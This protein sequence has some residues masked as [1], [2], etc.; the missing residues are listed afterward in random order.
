M[1]RLPGPE[2]PVSPRFYFSTFSLFWIISSNTAAGSD[3]G[4]RLGGLTAGRT[5]GRRNT[6]R[7]AGTGNAESRK[8]CWEEWWKGSDQLG[9]MVVETEN[10][11]RNAGRSQWEDVGRMAKLGRFLE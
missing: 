5:A 3:L 6:G 10:L 2:R 1:C 9:G 4:G 7:A 8:G 11:G